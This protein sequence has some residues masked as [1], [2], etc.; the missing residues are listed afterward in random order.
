M[1]SNRFD[2]GDADVH[3][4]QASLDI[5]AA[6]LDRF[7]RLLSPEELGRAERF[8]ISL[9]RDRFVAARAMLRVLLGNYV[10]KAPERLEF[11]YGDHGKP[12]LSENQVSFN[13]SHCGELCLFA[14]ALQRQVGVD[15]EHLGR[16]AS[17]DRIARRFF[18]FE[19]IA[20][21]IEAPDHGKVR[22]FFEIWTRK[23]AYLKS[24][25]VGISV[26]LD[27]FA[28]TSGP[29]AMI[30]RDDS[31]TDA[32]SKWLLRTVDAGSEFAAA[33]CGQGLHWTLK[34]RIWTPSEE[35]L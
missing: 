28:L 12:G 11:C 1:A 15:I 23:E 9:V 27:S 29:E 17:I 2:L 32:G 7:R 22:V 6:R 19:E 5:S 4:W 13:I 8:R 20:S 21:V 26:P 33:I 16:K 25:G 30:I 14:F 24:R 18:A 3:V 34:D 10:D 31:D 35:L